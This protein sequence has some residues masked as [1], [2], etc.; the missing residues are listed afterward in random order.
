MVVV[1]A[2]K[3]TRVT[4]A[5]PRAPA[6]AMSVG[7][8]PSG[9]E[10][11]LAWLA[12]AIVGT[13]VATVT[14]TA[15]E[16]MTAVLESVTRA[17]NDT[18]PVAVGVQLKV[19]VTLAA[20]VA[21][22]KVPRNA[23]PAKK[24]TLETVPLAALA[25]A[26]RGTWVPSVTVVP[27]VGV[28]RATLGPVTETLTMLEVAEA[29]VESV[30]LAVSAVMPAAVGVQVVENGGVSTVPTTEDPTRKS[31]FVTVAVPAV[32]RVA[33]KIVVVPSAIGAPFVGAASTAANVPG[34]AATFTL[35]APDVTIVPFESVTRAVKAAVPAAA[36]VQ[37]TL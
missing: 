2:R 24:S 21:G 36:G 13:D 25:V 11:P 9:I 3:S 28:V 22:V 10:A 37:L 19:A 33:V 29:P 17:V 34:A 30:T 15:V 7:E 14:A 5:P 4:V 16:V 35:T 8:V 1:P 27:A 31:T 23:A 26:L 6:L 12:M 18:A 32:V 20:G